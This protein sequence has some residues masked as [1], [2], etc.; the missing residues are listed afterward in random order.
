M[1]MIPNYMR[2]YSYTVAQALDEFAITFFSL[3]NS[4]YRIQA[5]ETLDGALRVSVGMAGKDAASTQ[6]ELQKQS[7]GL[8]GVLEEV[9]VAEKAAKK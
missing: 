5:N 6:K 2:F 9:H 1:M 3:V 4:M 7:R 8:H